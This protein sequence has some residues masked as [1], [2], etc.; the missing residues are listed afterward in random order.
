[1]EEM[2]LMKVR[3]A[4]LDQEL[5]VKRDDIQLKEELLKDRYE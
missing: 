3:Q 1:M 5:S 4:D 2:Y